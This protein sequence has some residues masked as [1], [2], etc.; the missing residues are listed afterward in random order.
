VLSWLAGGT[1]LPEV[2]AD[3]A[4]SADMDRAWL[5]R[6]GPSE[7]WH[8]LGGSDGELDAQWQP[9]QEL[10]RR[11][12][13]AQA[14]EL[15]VVPQAQR[16]AVFQR[17]G[18]AVVLA[19]VGASGE[20]TA[21]LGMAGRETTVRWE[22]GRRTIAARAQLLAVGLRARNLLVERQQYERIANC[23]AAATWSQQ[24]LGELGHQLRG[25]VPY[26]V[27]T[28]C[29]HGPS[30]RY[31]EHW[32]IDGAGARPLLGSCEGDTPQD[33]ELHEGSP[34]VVL[35]SA[36]E[37]SPALEGAMATSLQAG[38]E[39]LGRLSLGRVGAPFH[40]EDRQRVRTVA[41]VLASALKRIR[42]EGQLRDTE[43]QAALGGITRMLAH[44]LRNP[45]NSLGLHLQLLQ[46]RIRQLE[47]NGA[48]D[49]VERVQVVHEEIKRLDALVQHYVGL[50]RS[51]RWNLER[52]DLRELVARSLRVHADRFAERGIAVEQAL[53][54][55]PALV[56]G[57]WEKLG[58]V[59][60]NVIRNAV[61]AMYCS[62][63][64][65]L[66]F[67]L[68]GRETEWELHVR[69]TGC[70][71]E[72][73]KQ[74]FSPSYSTKD[75]GTGMGLAIGRRIVELHGGHLNAAQPRGGGAELVLTLPRAG[76]VAQAKPQRGS[77][78]AESAH[79]A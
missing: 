21:W 61:E 59:L 23:L 13:D 66:H 48:A 16:P 49:A 25:L 30:G 60:D 4:E 12:G 11:A 43:Q 68:C 79:G 32:R 3:A 54:D 69:D 67:W 76:V 18:V 52:L 51:D 2:L 31:S 50:S 24:A 10:A 56:E 47:G 22:E 28:L 20:P 38:S 44:D 1:R 17:R 64:R 73:P 58:Q 78:S 62:P 35:C 53:A 40:E 71:L 63:T 72:D 36:L 34:R 19:S 75:S 55:E 39:V 57:D 14:G 70:G 37:E 7:G 65:E 77:S 41:P 5:I 6:W 33:V 42:V 15:W 46:R 27:A 45:L 29:L 26:D 74:I 8:Y 9:L